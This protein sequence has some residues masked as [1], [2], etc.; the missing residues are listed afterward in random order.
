MDVDRTIA[1]VRT[2]A[3]DFS[4]LPGEVFEVQPID[5]PD[6]GVYIRDNS[7]SL[8]RAAYRQRNAN[9]SRIIDAVAKH[10]EQTLE[11]AHQAIRARRVTLSFVGVDSNSQKFGVAP[12]G[13]LVIGNNDPSRGRQIVP[14]FAL[15][16]ASTEAS[17]MFQEPASAGDFFASES[18]KPQHLEEGWLP[19]VITKW[20]RNDVSF[21]RCDYAA[22]NPAPEPLEESKLMGN[23]L[24]LLISRLAIRNE[25]PFPK[26]VSY[27]IKPWK[28]ASGQVDY[29]AI[30]KNPENAWETLC[31]TNCVFVAEGDS[32]YAVCSV[33]N[34]GR[35]SLLLEPA[36]SAVRYSLKLNPGEQHFIH[37][38]VPGR[39]LPGAER[40]K[41]RDLPYEA[42]HDSTVK[43]WKDRLA[44]G[45]QVE[46]PDQHVQNLYNAT[47]QHFLLV[48]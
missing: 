43:Y 46:I 35:G 34:H 7:L 41:L 15:Y 5:M 4:F 45:M 22:L 9:R 27:Y 32:E 29:G 28:P 10:S 48:P 33:D 19:I 21:E 12:D 16:F 30:P 2:K 40:D 38:V 8:D 11:D 47:L 26:T 17:T 3:F 18:E 39:P 42:L 31:R 6:F 13:H 44:E 24:A 25:S 1:T 37:I 36:A 14:K 20:S 23:E